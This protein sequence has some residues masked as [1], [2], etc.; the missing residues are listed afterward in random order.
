LPLE[1]GCQRTV[2]NKGEKLPPN[3]GDPHGSASPWPWPVPLLRESKATKAVLRGHYDPLFPE[4]ETDYPDQLRADEFLNEFA[5]FVQARKEGKG[6]ELPAFVLLYLPD[7]HTG[8]TRPGRP[9]PAAS[10]ADNDLALGRVA[11]AVSH[12]A[13][14]ADTA[15]FVVEDDA[16]DGADHVDAHRSIA[17]VVSKY[18]PG[19]VEKPFVDS[20]FYTT[21]NMIHTI[22]S[23]LG[24][25]QMNQNDAYAPL[26]APLFSGAGNQPPFAVDWSN[27]ENG[28]IYQVNP[29]KGQGAKESAKMD[30]SR[31]DAANNVVL[32]RILWRDRKGNAPM[33]ATK[34]TVFAQ[35]AA[36][37]D[38]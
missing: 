21:V 20:R 34:H 2:V 38:D 3:V 6:T 33:P 9:R 29:A 12:S 19:S 7:D 18:S 36:R 23:L 15:I 13:Y 26:M 32:N 1:S 14:W 24:L 28:L 11:D 25:P 37:D 17:F 10:V 35:T 16:Q 27:R 30:F 8:G 22:E 5:G 4:F 31:P